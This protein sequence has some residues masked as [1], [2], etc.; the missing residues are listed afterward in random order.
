MRNQTERRQRL[1][2]G[3]SRQRSYL[4]HRLRRRLSDLGRWWMVTWTSPPS[5]RL[6]TSWAPAPWRRSVSWR[7]QT[8][9]N[10]NSA[11][12]RLQ[13]KYQ[14]GSYE[15]V[16]GG[17]GSRQ[18]RPRRPRKALGRAR[19]QKSGVGRGVPG[20]R[21]PQ[22]FAPF[23]TPCGL[24][25]PVRGALEATWASLGILGTPW[26]RDT[27]SNARALGGGN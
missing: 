21:C 23:W 1:L 27:F 3:F 7:R 10:S 18:V 24:L 15:C 8:C 12:M 20:P 4:L 13:S 11:R 9:R 22:L 25:G 2:A 26:A 14:N 16:Q 6:T 19:D 17:A 5:S